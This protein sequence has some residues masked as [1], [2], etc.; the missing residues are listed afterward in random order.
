[1]W[2]E[3]SK[4]KQ[5]QESLADAIRF[6]TN[7]YI[8]YFSKY[9]PHTSYVSCASNTTHAAYASDSKVMLNCFNC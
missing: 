1:M 3:N 7:S 6:A 2:H 5:A 9:A 4:K 8:T